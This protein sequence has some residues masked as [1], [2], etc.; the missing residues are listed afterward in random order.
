MLHKLQRLLK[1]LIEGM[2][3]AMV[4]HWMP[5]MKMSARDVATIALTAASTFAVLDFFAPSMSNSARAGTG[6]SIGAKLG[7]FGR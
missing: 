3:V 5:S 4:A 1:Y 7:G 2:V 6:L